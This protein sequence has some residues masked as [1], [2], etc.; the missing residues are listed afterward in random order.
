MPKRVMPTCSGGLERRQVAKLALG[1]FATVYLTAHT[2]Y[3]Q[4]TVYR[5]RN[6]FIVAS[7]TDPRALELA[8]AVVT[9]LNRELPESHARVTRASNPVRIASLLATGQLDVAII[10]RHEASDMYAGKEAFAEIGPIP[11]RLLAKLNEHFFVTVESFRD[12]HA[13]LLAEAVEHIRAELQLRPVPSQSQI[14]PEHP[15]AAA[16][17]RARTQ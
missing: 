2:P 11:L 4:W 13:F 16:Y 10:S 7:R 17:Y 1:L 8:R 3:G 14:I 15:G 6:L 9:G 5:Q 12:R